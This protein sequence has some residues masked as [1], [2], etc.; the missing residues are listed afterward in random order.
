MIISPEVIED[1]IVQSPT[2]SARMREIRLRMYEPASTMM[3]RG[4][5]IM[6]SNMLYENLSIIEMA[7]T[8]RKDPDPPRASTK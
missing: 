2:R 4:R 3:T 7:S 1:V 6:S 5:K 8:K